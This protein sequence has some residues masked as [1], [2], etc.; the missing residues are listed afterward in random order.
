MAGFA[1]KK[2]FKLAKGF[3]GRAKNCLKVAIPKVEKSLLYAYIGRKQRP[4]KFR[5]EWIGTISAAVRDHGVMYSRFMNALTYSNIGLNRKVLA[6]L[7]ENEPYSFKAIVDELKVQ[8]GLMPKEA[9][10]TVE[11][12]IRKNLIVKHK[13][14]EA[15]YKEKPD[16]PIKSEYDIK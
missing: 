3:Y 2:Y 7:A 13:L 11:E 4:R 10:F 9:P 1:K 5:R 14:P 12:M 15:M 8:A 6:D 16:K